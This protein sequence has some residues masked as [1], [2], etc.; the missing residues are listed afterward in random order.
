MNTT[1]TLHERLAA[2]RSRLIDAGI[3]PAEAGL[4][5]DLYARTILGWDRTRLLAEQAG[6]M[7]SSLEPRFS[8]WIERRERS[9]PSAYIIGMR[10]FWGREFRVS[11]A[12]LIPRPETEFIIE[13]ALPRLLTWRA[14][15]SGGRGPVIADIGTGSGC[16]AV[17][18][19]CEVPSS[20]VVASDVSAEALVVARE[21]ADRFG[22]G[23]RVELVCSSYLD[24]VEGT[25]D[26]IVAN[27]PYVKDHDKPGLSRD[28]RHEPDI[29]LFGGRDGLR[30]IDRVIE[31]AA[32][33]LRRNGW[34]LMEFG[35]GQEDDVRALV[36]ARPSLRLE[37]VREDF[38]GIPRTMIIQRT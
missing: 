27:P 25:F 3:S 28:V 18:L 6:M 30:D 36:A 26:L 31:T 7:P 10:E 17:T 24:G 5:V 14:T 4:D 13:E 1:L 29:A 32:Q 16:L 35:Y 2:A 9:E 15:A 20:R 8:E 19:A 37:H 23:D 33:R 22:V 12:V 38:Q 11:P 21:N 34:F